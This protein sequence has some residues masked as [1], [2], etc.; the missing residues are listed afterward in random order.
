MKKIIAI[1]VMFALIAG[2]VFADTALAGAVETRFSL[3]KQTG[4]PDET[5]KGNQSTNGGEDAPAPKMGGSVAAA[6][7]RLSG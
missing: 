1:S 7:I 6:Q 5:K 4:F 2:A 3:A